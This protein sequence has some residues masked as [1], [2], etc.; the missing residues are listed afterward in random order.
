MMVRD[1]EALTRDGAGGAA[2]V[3]SFP[4]PPLPADDVNE[5]CTILA[6]QVSIVHGQAFARPQQTSRSELPAV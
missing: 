3:N 6:P 4:P 1:Q 2:S 5:G